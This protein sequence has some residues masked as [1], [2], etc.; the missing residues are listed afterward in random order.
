MA[1]SPALVRVDDPLGRTGA[2]QVVTPHR[3]IA[4]ADVEPFSAHV[5]VTGTDPGATSRR[6][7]CSM[8]DAIFAWSFWLAMSSRRPG[9]RVFEIEIVRRRTGAVTLVFAFYSV[10]DLDVDASLPRRI[11]NVFFHPSFVRS[12]T[13]HLAVV[14]DAAT[15]GRAGR[16]LRRADVLR[17]LRAARPVIFFALLF[18]PIET[19][20][21]PEWS[22]CSPRFGPA[23]PIRVIPD[24]SP[25]YFGLAVARLVP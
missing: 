17:G 1:R 12:S 3:R 24:P 11:L 13:G 6:P 7:E 20:A 23:S 22:K 16:D 21:G 4:A 25:R 18:P 15:S 10:S 14:D 2:N 9:L 19:A 5:N 8:N